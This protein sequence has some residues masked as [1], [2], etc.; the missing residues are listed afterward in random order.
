MV[1]V[2]T[3]L[4]CVCIIEKS[5]FCRAALNLHISFVTYAVIRYIRV[6]NLNFLITDIKKIIVVF[7]FALVC[8]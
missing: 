6:M 3:A 2:A 1:A 7:V 4:Q 5:L 8:L